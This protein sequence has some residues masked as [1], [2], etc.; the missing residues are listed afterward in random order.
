VKTGR[1]KHTLGWLVKMKADAGKEE[2]TVSMTNSGARV[3]KQSD[4]RHAPSYN[5]QLATDA[6]CG[7]SCDSF[8]L[9]EDEDGRG[10]G[11]LQ[12]A[13]LHCRISPMPRSR[14][15][16]ALVVPSARI[17]SRSG[18][19]RCGPASP[20]IQQW[21]GMSTGVMYLTLV[22]ICSCIRRLRSRAYT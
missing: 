6:Q 15:T 10:K 18:S 13:G 21:V 12:A 16:W 9:E 4:G 2:R 3:M 20:N 17:C 14:R 5:V 7:R 11:Y 8:F 19:K 1:T 22:E